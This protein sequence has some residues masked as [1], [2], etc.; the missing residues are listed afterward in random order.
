M[1]LRWRLTAVIG[2]V[3][4][5]MLFTASFLAYVSAERE[6]NHQVDEFLLTR[7]RETEIGLSSAGNSPL[8]LSS[9]E[10]ARFF[11]TLDA[12]TRADA[13][14]Q[15]LWD[16]GERALIIS[17]PQLPV[18]ADDI[19]M[20]RLPR[21]RAVARKTVDREIDGVTYRILTSSNPQGA[22]MVGRS[23]DDITQTLDGLRGWLIMIS[24][25]GSLAAGL[26]GWLVADRVLR[27]VA[28]LAA[29]TE[30]VAET[31]RF[32]AD[33]RV[34]G[35]DELGALARSFNSMLS[36]L[37]ASREQQER[38][39]RDANHEL[40]TPLTSLRTNVD[41]LR[42]RGTDLGAAEREA[43]IDEM[44]GEVRELTELVSE[45]VGFATNSATLSPESF[46]EVD[47]V[48]LCQEAAGRTVRRTGRQIEVVGVSSAPILGDPSGLERAIG[49]LVGNAVK[50]TEADAPIEIVV[51]EDSVE[52]H[53][54]GPGIVDSDLDRIFDRFYR[55]DATRTMPGSG[56]GLA[57]VS[58]IALAHGGGTHARNRPGGGAIVGF[59]VEPDLP[60]LSA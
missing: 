43:L 40:R 24:I 57:I 3:V 37:R 36:T 51:G 29:A 21:Q 49:N 33:L 50:F 28:R 39:V 4:A 34:Q 5:L 2:G 10:T 6:L 32:D 26:V 54:R 20:A 1:S 46:V 56:L 25:S 52:V 27:P 19:E 13:S 8:D 23:I 9:L 42:R 11:G 22:L 30:Q 45:L 31:R 41:V 17:E 14:I 35:R 53:D 12:L 55:A 44:D 58:D 16:S 59:T 60:S 48:E 15:L 7:S 18:L 47:L 38:L